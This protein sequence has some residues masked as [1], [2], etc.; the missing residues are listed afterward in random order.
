MD[1]RLTYITEITRKRDKLNMNVL[2]NNYFDWLKEYL[3][4][5]IKCG[6]IE[7]IVDEIG[8]V[9]QPTVKTLNH[10]QIIIYSDG[11]V[12]FQIG[13]IE[14]YH[15]DLT[16]ANVNSIKA[17]TIALISNPVKV[18][19]RFAKSGT[20]ISKKISYFLVNES[21]ITTQFTECFTNNY[22][23]FIRAKSFYEI[24]NQE[25]WI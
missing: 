6:K 11:R 24:D 9:F 10:I 18:K 12:V 17:L 5:T 22:N 19:N 14:V 8:T 15:E 1:F 7:I 3:L 23:P 13:E 16:S 2:I 4:Q 25:S 20:L 21:E